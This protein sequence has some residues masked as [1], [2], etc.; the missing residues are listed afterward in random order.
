M[1]FFLD[2]AYPDQASNR[3]ELP[4]G[5]YTIGRGE[6]CKIRLRHPEISE[7]HALLTLRETGITIEDLHSSNG[8]VVDGS[9]IQEPTRLHA[10]D[11]VG[12]GPCLLRVSPAVAAPAEAPASPTPPPLPGPPRAPLPVPA[13]E[14]RPPEPAPMPAP[15]PADPM[16]AILREIKNQIHGELIQRL[17]LKRMTV[18]RIGTNELQQKARETIR[19]I[20]AEVRR[21][22][23]LPAGIDPAR[24]EKEIYDE[25]MRL[26]PLEDF[27]A[28]EAITEIMVN[29]PGQVFV[30]RNGRIE[31]TG[32]TFMDDESVLGVI[33]RI[34]APIGRRI[35]ESQPY[36]DAR[37]PDGS[38]VNAIIAPLSLIGPCITIRKFSKRALTVDDFIAFGTWTRSAAEFLRLCVLMRK[39]IVVA[40]GT[41]S[42]KTT[43]L[44]VLSGFIPPTD[45]IV[46]IEDAAELRLVQPHVIRLEARPPNI[47]GRGA[48]TIR[49]LV[50]NALR[51]RPDRI[52][53]G[54]CR[55][56]ES[57]DML[58]AMNT[59][60]DGSL[61]TVHAN[62]P[63]D[64][65]SRLE[66][67]VLM[68]GLELPSRAIREQIASAID[69]VVHESRLS[70]GSRKVTCI[71]E[72]VGLE[73][74]Q[75]VMQD[76]FE[77]KQTGVDEKGKVLG[78]FMPT[79]AVPTFFEHLKSRGLHLDPA[80][81]DP[82]KQGGDA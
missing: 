58:Q 73:G 4:A 48:I 70:D 29:G 45:R 5:L 19:S 50:R 13:V 12:L 32:Q 49:D 35:D 16:A 60:H 62:S 68:S 11:V 51:M 10:D 37:L 41:G 81:F 82:S 28:D 6:A 74:L 56:G 55:S 17:D 52:I 71:S 34:V 40:G 72:V 79:G 77:F 9:P 38:R 30:E 80:I 25:A 47:E 18:S 3:F 65:I 33:E 42:G 61:T 23:K 2:I 67:M 44:N 46:T 66:T 31:L 54:E 20:I 39:N 75:I 1:N 69:L 76:L 78:S 15:D 22:Q 53:V 59:G 36:V 27:L 7:R 63:R 64:V 26:G 14:P 8:T 21:N 24:L 57:L 43:L